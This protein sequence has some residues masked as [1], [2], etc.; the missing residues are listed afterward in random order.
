[1]KLAEAFGQPKLDLAAV[2]RKMD[3]VNQGKMT[4]HTMI[5]EPAS[6]RLHLAVGAGP[7]SA[8]PLE[9]IDLAPLFAPQPA[10]AE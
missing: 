6:L 3:A 10:T 7:V 2:A 4:I 5:F 8:Q 9:A 1:M